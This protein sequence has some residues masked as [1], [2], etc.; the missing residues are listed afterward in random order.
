V[1]KLKTIQSKHFVPV[2]KIAKKNSQKECIFV[3]SALKI[4]CHI[5]KSTL[6][7]TAF[8]GDFAHW[9][10]SFRN[11]RIKQKQNSNFIPFYIIVHL[12]HIFV[13]LLPIQH[14]MHHLLPNL[15]RVGGYQPPV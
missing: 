12:L 2:G 15:A 13:F 10:N 8:F 14:L 11:K 6:L 5:V 3:N 7:Q 4:Q 9:E 1:N